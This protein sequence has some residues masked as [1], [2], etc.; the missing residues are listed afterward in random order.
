MSKSLLVMGGGTSNMSD[1]NTYY[2]SMA[3][4]VSTSYPTIEASG[5]TPIREAGSFSNLW[6]YVPTNNITASSVLTLRKSGSN[7][8]MTVTYTSTQTGTKEDA[9]SV[10][11]ANTDT[12]NWRMVIPD[13]TGTPFLVLASVSATFDPTNPN[14][15]VSWFRIPSSAYAISVDSTT[16]YPV[17]IGRTGSGT[18]EADAQFKFYNSYTVSNLYI[19]V[20]ANTRTTNT[21]V[22]FRKNSGDGVMSITY[23]SG[24]TGTKEYTSGTDS[25][26]SGDLACLAI[27]TSTG[28]GTIT[29]GGISS[30]IISNEHV[31]PLLGGCSLSGLMIN[32]VGAVTKYCQISGGGG[33]NNSSTEANT[34][35]KANHNFII[36]NM[37]VNVF[38]NSNGS[39]SATITVRKNGVSTDMVIAYAAGETGLKEL[40]NISV[41]VQKGDLINFEFKNTGAGTVLFSCFGAYG[42]NQINN[43]FLSEYL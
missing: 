32:L 22:K 20:T 8:A 34:Q 25:L 10:S 13:V 27:T 4:R 43:Y 28:G 12:A 24:E 17:L 5:Q 38:S 18:V 2:W 31:F 9:T 29:F 42:Y 33:I 19:H 3:G 15:C 41:S 23:S 26:V 6:I 40:K 35:V 37:F 14:K 36:R 16:E 30:Q 21:V 7:T 39:G 1:N 11:F